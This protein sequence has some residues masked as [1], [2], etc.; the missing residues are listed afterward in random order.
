MFIPSVISKETFFLSGRAVADVAR[1]EIALVRSE[2]ALL[3]SPCYKG[4]KELVSYLESIST[5][6]ID[7][8]KPDLKTLFELKCTYEGNF[9][10]HVDPAKPSTGLMRDDHSD[11]PCVDSDRLDT[12]ASL[13]YKDALDWCAEHITSGST[14]SPET[15]LEIHSRCR[16][17]TSFTESGTAFRKAEFTRP[18]NTLAH[19]YQP[20]E[21]QDIEG[22]VEDLCD[23]IN[24]DIY[25]PIIQSAIA[26]FQFECIKPFKTAMDRT[27]RAMSH[28]IFFRRGFMNGTITPISLLPTLNTKT[29]AKLLLPYD[30]GN[31]ID[32]YV[33]KMQA[34]N[35]WIS[36]CALAADLAADSINVIANMVERLEEHWIKQTGKIT[37]GSITEELLLLLPAHPI[38]TV[39]SAMTLTGRSFSAANDALNRLAQAGVLAVSQEPHQKTRQFRSVE[40]FDTFEKAIQRIVDR[41]PVSRNSF[42]DCYISLGQMPTPPCP[43]FKEDPTSE[44]PCCTNNACAYQAEQR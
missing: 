14:I 33:H 21:A 42:L 5:V 41:E 38:L 10:N 34:V 12:L 7:G 36:F 29:H 22:L 43:L 32:E 40:C 35:H 8:Q 17:G 18:P 6:R 9:V 3:A 15:L 31:D 27:G 11:L 4:L 44:K 16:F 2:S 20:P 37:K 25:S 13:R 28:A 19:N 24:Q 30:T 1:A 23:F 26:H 39:S